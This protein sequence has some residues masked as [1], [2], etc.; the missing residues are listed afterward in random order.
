MRGS[1]GTSQ[2]PALFWQRAGFCPASESQL[3]QSF[4]SDHQ[5]ATLKWILEGGVCNVW[6]VCVW[7]CR[8]WQGGAEGGSNLSRG[9]TE[10]QRGSNGGGR[11]KEASGGHPRRERNSFLKQRF[12]RH[13]TVGMHIWKKNQQ[14]CPLAGAFST[15]LNE[16]CNVLAYSV[17]INIFYACTAHG[18]VSI[19]FTGEKK[20]LST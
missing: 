7:L 3:L 20:T 14:R 18:K 12:S 4:R 2:V 15:P 16:K 17:F 8:G 13:C 11:K 19:L 5:P 1:E 6:W 10:S 9:Q